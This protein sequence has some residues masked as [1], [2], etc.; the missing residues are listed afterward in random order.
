MTIEIIQEESVKITVTSPE[1]EEEHTKL[2]F[3]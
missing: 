3:S 1:K 2:I